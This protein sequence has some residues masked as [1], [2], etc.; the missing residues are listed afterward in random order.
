MFSSGPDELFEIVQ[1]T[2]PVEPRISFGRTPYIEPLVDPTWQ[3]R[4]C[5]VLVNR[6][7]ARLLAG[8]AGRLSAAERVADD[9]RGQSEGGGLVAGQLPARRR[10]RGR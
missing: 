3:R 10:G 9:V 4:W 7:E 1:L 2:R 5:I 6:R 8:E